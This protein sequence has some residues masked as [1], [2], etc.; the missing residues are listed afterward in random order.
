[1][2]VLAGRD[3]K[4][5]DAG[6]TSDPYC[7]LHAGG[8]RFKTRTIKKT[9]NPTW[10]ETFTTTTHS[11]SESVIIDVYDRDKYSRDDKLG[12]VEIPFRGLVPG[13]PSDQWHKLER[14]HRGEVHIRLTA[15]KQ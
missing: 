14:V 12:C 7:K 6:G 5:A 2:E 8:Q 13:V 11:A 1:M 9:L 15:T 3:L 4:A 10:N